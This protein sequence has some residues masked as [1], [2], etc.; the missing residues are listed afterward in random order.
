[1]FVMLQC[2]KKKH[3]FCLKMTEPKLFHKYFVTL[4]L[5]E[6]RYLILSFVRRS[7]LFCTAVAVRNCILSGRY[8]LK[9][10]WTC[11]MSSL[12]AGFTSIFSV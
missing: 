4:I 7:I 6:F 2:L 11:G 12:E 1:M 8:K 5:A 9:S 3:F 10:Y